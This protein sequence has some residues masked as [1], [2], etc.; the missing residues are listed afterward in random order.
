[1]TQHTIYVEHDGDDTILYNSAIG[2]TTCNASEAAGVYTITDAAV[3]FTAMGIVVDQSAIVIQEASLNGPAFTGVI[4]E[5]TNATTI[6]IDTTGNLPWADAAQ[7]T[8]L[9]SL[10]SG[11]N[12]DYFREGHTPSASGENY[13]IYKVH[14][15][16]QDLAFA[17][18]GNALHAGIGENLY[19]TMQELTIIQL[20]AGAITYETLVFD[21]TDGIAT[22][23]GFT[24]KVVGHGANITYIDGSENELSAALL[25]SHPS[26]PSQGSVTLEG[27]GIRNFQY[28]VQFDSQPS[29]SGDLL[30]PSQTNLDPTLDQEQYEV[31]WKNIIR[32]CWFV[33]V[34]R[35][36]YCSDGIM[37]IED[38][39]FISSLEPMPVSPWAHASFSWTSP[40]NASIL[41]CKVKNNVFY[42]CA[43][44]FPVLF[45][46]EVT[47]NIVVG[48]TKGA[49]VFHSYFSGSAYTPVKVLDNN[50]YFDCDE[51]L[52]MCNLNTENTP[53]RYIRSGGETPWGAPGNTD[54]TGEEITVYDELSSGVTA[55]DTTLPIDD[56][57][58]FA[59]ASANRG[60]LRI[61]DELILFMGRTGTDLEECYR[62]VFGTTAASHLSGA[63]VDLIPNFPFANTSNE[64]GRSPSYQPGE[65]DTSTFAATQAKGSRP[66]G[67][68]ENWDTPVLFEID[69][70]EE[71]PDFVDPEH[72]CFVARPNGNLVLDLNYDSKVCGSY[73]IGDGVSQKANGHL[74]NLTSTPDNTGIYD[75]DGA[76]EFR[77]GQLFMK[78]TGTPG[79]VHQLYFPV[80]DLKA[81][82]W[83][84]SFEL[85]TYGQGDA[86][87]WG[88]DTSRAEPKIRFRSSDSS[89]S[90]NPAIGP[91]WQE[92]KLTEFEKFQARYV[93][94]QLTARNNGTL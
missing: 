73:G 55:T 59:G 86:R 25:F 64:H 10:G 91:A 62:G 19:G 93:Q 85:F 9:P 90:Q 66:I 65:E 74:W 38:N 20:P 50:L 77:L 72:Q 6:K 87:M 39:V 1:M 81:K 29:V 80:R 58:L 67:D 11:T 15:Y 44:G 79:S 92:L 70:R 82:R 4:T 36:L 52:Y 57:T 31:Y 54:G 24:F 56:D 71:E 32:N 83:V 18:L 13:Y 48:S 88:Y 61:D 2:G 26:S 42:K 17:T 28:G 60:I 89:F 94:I 51:F 35:P 76:F 47:E 30:L 75:P 41:P 63:H 8:R 40:E 27:I 78:S 23:T 33:N 5:V 68:I 22:N 16:S 37:N 53:E 12:A 45:W 43:Y 34:D 69:G 7:T 3:D 14:G 21:G 84:R 49:I 46:G